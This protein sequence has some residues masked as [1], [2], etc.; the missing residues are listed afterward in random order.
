M[1]AGYFSPMPPARTGIADYS[2]ALLQEL[3]KLGTV[4]LNDAVADVRLY[5]LGNNQLHRPIYE[6]A[7]AVPGV[8]VLHDAVLQHFFLGWLT[9]TEYI[10]EFVYNYGQWHAGLAERLWRNRARSGTEALYFRYPMIR[11]VVERSL[12]VIVHNG[13]AARVVRG[14]VPAARVFEIPHIL[15]PGGQPAA[16]EVIRL[17]A[18]LGVLPS[19]CL[20]GVFGHLRE[21]KRLM[22]V[23]HVFQNLRRSGE[24]VKLVVA[25]EFVSSDLARGAGPLLDQPGI[26][27]AGYTPEDL[28]WIYA[29]AVDAAI[30]LRYPTAGETS[31]IAIRMMG[32]GKPV[33]LTEGEETNSI[34]EAAALRVDAGPAE[35]DMLSEYMLWLTR[36]RDDARAIGERAR[37]H[38]TEHHGGAR[39][40]AQYW[41]ALAEARA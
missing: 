21:S 25:G 28:F 7:L 19:D 23:L 4:N 6:Q 36:F 20:F 35:S 31:G 12:A 30:N 37:Q 41:Q 5:H 17:R 14:H 10:A 3:R 11:R 8:I 29:H 18:R 13:A 15:L 40:A 27:R 26:V 1:T 2:A 39:V 33:L 24:R 9:E 32:I 34:P 38:I 16:Y 22:T